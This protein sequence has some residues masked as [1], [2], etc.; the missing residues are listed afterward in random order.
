MLYDIVNKKKKMT[1]AATEEAPNG[2]I[3]A[4]LSIKIN[5]NINLWLVCNKLWICKICI[6]CGL[7]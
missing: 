7:I 3:W 2:Q 4:K 1:Q 6:N 5:N